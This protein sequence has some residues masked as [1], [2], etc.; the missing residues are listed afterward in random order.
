[1]TFKCELCE[2]SELCTEKD[3]FLHIGRHLKSNE[4]VSCVFHS[5]PFK[6]NIYN[7]FYTHKK[8]KHHPYVLKDFKASVVKCVNPVPQS[9]SFDTGT[10]E[11][12]FHIPG[13]GVDNL[14][15]EL[16]FLLNS[17]CA[18]AAKHTIAETFKIY[19]IDIDQATVEEL[20]NSVC[21]SNPVATVLSKCGPLSTSHKR[22]KYFFYSHI[23]EL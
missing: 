4:T 11:H 2:C 22:K 9:G 17:A 15:E 13:Q 7:T 1:M 18:P 6:T 16:H 8:R 21:V 14:V 3:F 5:C 12:I 10:T 20:A 19:N 23:L